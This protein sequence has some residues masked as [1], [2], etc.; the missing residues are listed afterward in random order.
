MASLR[1]AHETGPSASSWL[2]APEIFVVPDIFAMQLRESADTH[3]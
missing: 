1:L 2:T 3:R